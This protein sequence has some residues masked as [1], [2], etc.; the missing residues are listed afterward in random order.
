[1]SETATRDAS[2]FPA[3]VLVVDD[4]PGMLDLMDDLLSLGGYKMLRATSGEAALAAAAAQAP[5][6]AFVDLVL[7]GLDGV[8][9]IERLATQL[10]ASSAV[11]MTGHHEHPRIDVA[12]GLGVHAILPKP[13][14]F[15]HILAA[16]GEICR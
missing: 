5:R 15:S 14:S 7:P 16:L 12:R 8:A 3:R 13:L 10:P 1:M 4:D 2:A 9:V 6:A 11:L